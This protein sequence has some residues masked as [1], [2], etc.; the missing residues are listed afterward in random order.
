MDL[1]TIKTCDLVTELSKREG[2]QKIVAEPYEAYTA[3]VGENQISDSGPALIMV[4]TD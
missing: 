3:T 2:V 1:S 4:V